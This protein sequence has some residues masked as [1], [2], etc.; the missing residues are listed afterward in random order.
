MDAMF[1]ALKKTLHQLLPEAS[2]QPF[3]PQESEK[4]AW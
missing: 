2:T 1:P 3:P 4:K